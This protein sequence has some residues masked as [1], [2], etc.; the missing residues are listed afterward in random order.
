MMMCSG[1]HGSGPSQCTKCKHVNSTDGVCVKECLAYEY[2]KDGVKISVTIVLSSHLYVVGSVST[3]VCVIG[4][5]F[6][7]RTN[8]IYNVI[9]DRS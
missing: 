3:I 7:A 6:T 4:Q 1:C 9:L 2:E 8:G 5:A